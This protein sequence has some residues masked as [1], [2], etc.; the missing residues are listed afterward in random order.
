MTTLA[1]SFPMT[2]VAT[3]YDLRAA[4]IDAWTKLL[5][6]LKPDDWDR[7]TVCDAWSVDDIVRHLV[8]QAEEQIWPW[9]F[10][11]RDHKA[12]RAYPEVPQLDAHMRYGA[13][14]HR[15]KSQEETIE[16][17]LRVWPRANRAMR[18]IPAIIRHVKVPGEDANFGTF[19][20]AL[21]DARAP[22]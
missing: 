4:E 17:F 1:G 9:Q 18:R 20:I 16:Y 10:P 12:T 21:A 5:E 7:P 6:D 22:F 13:D 11:L 19:R 3:A 15:A 8:S 2:D 14:L